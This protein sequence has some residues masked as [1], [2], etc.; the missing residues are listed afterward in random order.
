MTTWHAGIKLIINSVINMHYPCRHSVHE[1]HSVL[2]LIPVDLQRKLTFIHAWIPVRVQI[3]TLILNS[4]FP[5][6]ILSPQHRQ[7]WKSQSIIEEV[8]INTSYHTLVALHPN[9]L[10][11]AVLQEVHPCKVWKPHLHVSY[12]IMDSGDNSWC[13]L[14]WSLTLPKPYNYF[15]D[16]LNNHLSSNLC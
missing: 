14:M 1:A 12:L 13:A 16:L 5:D 11:I 6:T 2:P 3:I 7:V 8:R 10:V 9:G 15:P 4:F